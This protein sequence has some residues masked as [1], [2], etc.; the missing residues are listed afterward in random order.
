MLLREIKN[1]FHDELNALYGKEEVG[2]FFYLLIEDYFDLER[3]TL[4]MQPDMIISKAEETPMFDALSRLKLN[5]PIQHIIGKSHFMDMDFIVNKTVLIPRPETEELVRWVLNESKFERNRELR[6]LDIGTGS[7]CIAIS[8]AK[9]LPSAQIVALDISSSALEVAKENALLN[10]VD[11]TFLKADILKL[12]TLEEKFDIIVSNPPYVR[13]LEKNEMHKNVLDHEPGSALFVS[14]ENP[15]LFYRIITEFALNNLKE[16]GRLFF[17]INQY[18][19]KGTE[20]LL[21]DQNF[22]EIE[23]RKDMFNNNRMLRA[24]LQ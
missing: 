7:G 24:I 11:I 12:K 16:G 4:S 3:F 22:S 5:E 10:E 6:V 17:E 2:S 13:E 14:N 18:L 20:Q 23:V 8:L 21:K 1:I 9:N 19:A 15:L